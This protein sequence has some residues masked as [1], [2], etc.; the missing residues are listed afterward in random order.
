MSVVSLISLSFLLI[1]LKT[2]LFFFLI[3]GITFLQIFLK[4]STDYRIVH[5]LPF[6][7]IGNFIILEILSKKFTFL[8][9][10]YFILAC[11]LSQFVLFYQMITRI[12]YTKSI[13]VFGQPRNPWVLLERPSSDQQIWTVDAGH[14]LLMINEE[15]MSKK[16]KKLQG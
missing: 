4:G 5:I 11:Y 16:L 13:E 7:L 6:S 9:K 14:A 1:P 10:K 8:R 3:G 12:D 2:R 15:I